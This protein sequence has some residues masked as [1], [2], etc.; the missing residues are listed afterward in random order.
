MK[1]MKW[2]KATN[3]VETHEIKKGKTSNIWGSI[4]FSLEKRIYMK[5]LNWWISSVKK[6]I[7]YELFHRCFFIIR[8]LMFV[9]LF[10]NDVCCLQVT[11]GPDFKQTYNTLKTEI[12]IEFEATAK[13]KL[14]SR[15]RSK[16]ETEIEMEIEADWKLKPRSKPRSTTEIEIE[17]EIDPGKR[18]QNGNRLRSQKDFWKSTS[19]PVSETSASHT[20]VEVCCLYSSYITPWELNNR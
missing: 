18:D 19:S 6:Q 12:E 1:H 17:I 7:V 8:P 5:R 14:K 2:K 13:N 3:L 20:S 16:P 4:L 11:I 15:S 9:A 10:S